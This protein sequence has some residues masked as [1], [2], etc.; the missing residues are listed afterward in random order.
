MRG[1]Y[2]PI[3]FDS[4]GSK[5]IA[6]LD[7]WQS[8]TPTIAN[9]GTVTL[10]HARWKKVGQEIEIE[11]KFTTGTIGT[12]AGSLTL[13]NNLTTDVLAA[14]GKG[15]WHQAGASTDNFT[16]GTFQVTTAS[17]LLTFVDDFT[18]TASSG[19]VFSAASTA[20]L[21]RSTTIVTFSCKVS[22]TG[23]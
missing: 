12:G 23:W 5:S 15:Y 18:T 19:T 1:G 22:I 9:M 20:V 21:F 10:D 7:Q 16:R 2:S 11:G 14:M 4:G 3:I 13:P 8:W 17:N 6:P